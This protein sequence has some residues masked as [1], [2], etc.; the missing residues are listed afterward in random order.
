M[1]QVWLANGWEGPRPPPRCRLSA[2]GVMMRC[3]AP[4]PT[5]RRGVVGV[6]D[7]VMAGLVAQW[8][9]AWRAVQLKVRR[10]QRPQSRE[11]RSCALMGYITKPGMGASMVARWPVPGCAQ[12]RASR[13]M[14][15]SDPLP[16]TVNRGRARIG[17]FRAA[18]RSFCRALGSG[19]TAAPPDAGPAQPAVPSGKVKVLHRVHLQHAGGWL[20]HVRVHGAHIGRMRFQAGERVGRRGGRGHW[21]CPVLWGQKL[22]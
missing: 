14:S 12:A 15:S 3:T 17:F 8:R 22:G 2:H 1:S 11:P 9:P 6:G 19:S 18:R 16:S 5:A 7:V 20:H 13:V 10:Q 21:R 4:R